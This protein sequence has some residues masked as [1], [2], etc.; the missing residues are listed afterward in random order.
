[1]GANSAALLIRVHSRLI[2]GAAELLELP[3]ESLHKQAT[4]RWK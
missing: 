1:M 3:P 2:F 4:E